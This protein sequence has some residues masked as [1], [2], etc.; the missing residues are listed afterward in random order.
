MEPFV[1]QINGFLGNDLLSKIL[2]DTC[3][4]GV[5]ETRYCLNGILFSSSGGAGPEVNEFL[6]EN[7]L[8]TELWYVICGVRPLHH[9]LK[10]LAVNKV[11]CY[12]VIGTALF[13]SV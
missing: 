13:L 12:I 3:F 10:L 9:P 5:L 6:F 1:S 2:T 11:S 4:R 8:H 7:L